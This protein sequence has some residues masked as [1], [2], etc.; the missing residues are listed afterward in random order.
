VLDL[1]LISLGFDLILI[2]IWL[3]RKYTFLVGSVVEG[4][5]IY[6]LKMFEEI[7]QPNFPSPKFIKEGLEI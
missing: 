6:S 1:I 7:P 5:F 3:Y 4:L 2:N